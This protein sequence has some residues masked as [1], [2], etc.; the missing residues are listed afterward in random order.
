MEFCQ[1]PT[2]SEFT[3]VTDPFSHHF[4]SRISTVDGW[5]ISHVGSLVF[6]VKRRLW[7]NIC[8]GS[9]HNCHERGFCL[10]HW[11]PTSKKCL[12][13]E[14]HQNPALLRAATWTCRSRCQWYKGETVK[15]CHPHAL[16]RQACYGMPSPA[17]LP[18]SVPSKSVSA[19]PNC[20]T[21]A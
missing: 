1:D 11:P 15:V 2:Y 21:C 10:P 16:Q 4:W 8:C 12:R 20:L 6:E 3:E 19:A 17:G 14:T 7:L 9:K 18:V 5:S 13:G